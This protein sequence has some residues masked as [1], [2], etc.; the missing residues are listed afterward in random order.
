LLDTASRRNLELDYHPSGQMQY[1]LLSVL[2]NTA[3]AMGS[4][5]LRRWL[6]R[7]LRDQGVLSQRYESIDAL[8]TAGYRDLRALLQQV[9]DIERVSTRI[10]LKSARPRDLQ[11]LRHTLAVLPALQQALS[12]CEAPLLAQLA[13]AISPQPDL[14]LLLQRAVVDNPPVL[15]R[16]GG[17]LA[18]GY[19]QELDELRNLSQ[20]ADHYLI[21]METASGWP[22]ASTPLKSTLIGCMVL[23]RNF[24]LARKKSTCPLYAQANP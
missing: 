3:T 17:V 8:Q 16:D 23:H 5:C 13:H 15:I 18:K 2:D 21:D 11:V 10:A 6:N 12:V 1:T 7:P 14:L 9:G 22:R 19:S 20:N 4:R 24:S